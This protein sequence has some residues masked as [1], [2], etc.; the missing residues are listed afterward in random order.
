MLSGKGMYNSAQPSSTEL[1][2]PMRPKLILH[3]LLESNSCQNRMT[4]S[5]H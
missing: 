4:F 5:A 3:L 1:G 2:L